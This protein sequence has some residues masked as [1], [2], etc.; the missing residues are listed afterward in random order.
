MVADS[1]RAVRKA[2][3]WRTACEAIVATATGLLIVVLIAQLVTFNT[4][5]HRLSASLTAAQSANTQLKAENT[6]L[7]AENQAGAQLASANAVLQGQ[8]QTLRSEMATVLADERVG[9]SFFGSVSW[10]T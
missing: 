2:F 6:Q 10:P 9:E 7:K 1:N 8:V 5:N 4:T 3:P